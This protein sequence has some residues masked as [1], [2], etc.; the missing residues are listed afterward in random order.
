MIVA[1][2]APVYLTFFC[3]RACFLVFW[4]TSGRSETSFGFFWTFFGDFGGVA[5]TA[6]WARSRFTWKMQ[7]WNSKYDWSPQTN[8]NPTVL[9]RCDANGSN[10]NQKV[11]TAKI[12]ER[13]RATI[14]TMLPKR[15]NQTEVGCFSAKWNNRAK[16][17]RTSGMKWST[18]NTTA[19]RDKLAM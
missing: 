8:A 1:A 7:N 17:N 19:T 16:F 14:K 5:R 13:N 18:N 10:P 12:T 15:N 6:E 11:S 9:K 2:W 4:S 3:F